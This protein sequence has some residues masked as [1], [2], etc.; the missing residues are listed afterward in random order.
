MI[1]L[2]TAGSRVSVWVE[3][4]DARHV[5]HDAQPPELD[6]RKVHG[7]GDRFGIGHVAL[8][9]PGPAAFGDDLGR[10]VVVTLHVEA[11]DPAAPS[12]A[13]RWAV[14]RSIPEPAP[15]TIVRVQPEGRHPSRGVAGSG[16]RPLSNIPH[17]CLP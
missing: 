9:A 7:P 11:R 3:L 4:P 13:R 1:R 15:V 6:E 14:A 5:A 16:F 10:G 8:V 17:C 2:N 12:A